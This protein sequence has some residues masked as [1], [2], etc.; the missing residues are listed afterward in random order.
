MRKGF[1][2]GFT[3]IELM[4]TVAIV[5]LLASVAYPSYTN[6]IKK[7]ARRAA[8]AQ[9]LDLAARQQLYMLSNRMYAP[10]TTLT[11]NGFTFPTELTSKYTPDIVVGTST[12]PSY[13]I[14][15]TAK[16][17][18]LSDGDLTLTSEGK[19]LPADKW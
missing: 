17:T 3:L 12:V 10:Y 13:T 8:Q 14:T 9:M 6:H 7:G 11:A 19:K 18:Q 16:D 1:S 5:A 15:M 2:G 4:I